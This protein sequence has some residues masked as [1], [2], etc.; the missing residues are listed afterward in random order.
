MPTVEQVIQAIKGNEHYVERIFLRGGCYQFHLFLR[1]IFPSALPLINSANDHVISV[2]NGIGYDITG[3]VEIDDY[4]A[5]TASD[6][7]IAK[8][9]TFSK[10]QALSLGE[11]QFCGE[12]ILI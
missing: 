5:M 4:R 3:A 8:E 7:A 10:T 11:C 2:I 9:W 12:P 1:T 6:L